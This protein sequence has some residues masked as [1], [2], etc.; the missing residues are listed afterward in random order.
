MTQTPKTIKLTPAVSNKPCDIEYRLK[1][2]HALAS[3]C[4]QFLEGIDTGT[5]IGIA[6]QNA[7]EVARG[8]EAAVAEMR[9]AAPQKRIHGKKAKAASGIV[10]E[11]KAP[12]AKAKRGRKVKAATTT[13]DEAL[14]AVEETLDAAAE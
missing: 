11:P 2:A 5:P 6:L 9:S 3:E 12:K 10:E 14:A 7:Q 13:L 8:L 1:R 4:R